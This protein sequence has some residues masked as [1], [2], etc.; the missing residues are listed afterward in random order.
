MTVAAAVLI[1]LGLDPLQIYMGH[2]LP[3]VDWAELVQRSELADAIRAVTDDEQEQR[4]L[5]KIARFESNY[6][7]DVAECTK[8]GPQG[9][10][11]AW[12]VLARPGESIAAMCESYEA[13]ARIALERV[14]E[15]VR[16]CRSLPAEDRLALY[17]R[18][19]CSS[20]E[21]RRLSRVRYAP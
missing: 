20:A 12:Q 18:G 21:G 2:L 3:V 14:R 4:Q 6:R 15:S 16:A 10:V 11:T 7:R 17:T 8:R 1:L 9:E 13:G 19:R 5:A